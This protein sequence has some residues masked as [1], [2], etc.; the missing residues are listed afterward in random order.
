MNI[1]GKLFQDRIQAH[2][3][4]GPNEAYSQELSRKAREKDDFVRSPEAEKLILQRWELAGLY[5][6]H[7]LEGR[8]PEFESE[9]AHAEPTSDVNRIKAV[10]RYADG[11]LEGRF[12]AGEKHIVNDANIAAD[13]SIHIMKCTWLQD[14]VAPDEIRRQAH[15]LITESPFSG[16][17]ISYNYHFDPSRYQPSFTG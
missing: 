9:V 3:Y 17:S 4:S 7:V 12:E 10:Y 2:A 16:A 13:Y 11:I 5:A 6:K 14:D 8:W 15:D 1:L